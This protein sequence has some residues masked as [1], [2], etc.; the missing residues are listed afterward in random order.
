MAAALLACAAPRAL[1]QYTANSFA[2][3]L[4]W[5]LA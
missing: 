5:S 1:M 4:L 3:L 2:A